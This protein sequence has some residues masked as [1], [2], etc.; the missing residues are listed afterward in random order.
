MT[1]FHLD[2]VKTILGFAATDMTGTSAATTANI[3]RTGYNS[4]IVTVSNTAGTSGTLTMTAV[5]GA[6]TSPATSVSFDVAPAVITL[7]EAG[8]TKY[9]IDLSGF[10]ANFK[11]IFTPALSS[12]HSYVAVTVELWDAKIDPGSGTAITPLRKA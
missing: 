4:A 2:R 3:A 9:E 1:T 11:L 10:N 5:D 8:V 7:D 6:T 12:N